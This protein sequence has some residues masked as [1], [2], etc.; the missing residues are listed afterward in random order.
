MR[1]GGRQPAPLRTQARAVRLGRLLT[2]TMAPP[3]PTP[4]S[5]AFIDA[6]V[7]EHR[8]ALLKYLA[9]RGVPAQDAED[10]LQEVLQGA[11]VAYDRFDPERGS[12]RTWL[13]AIATNRL[14]TNRARRRR[15]PDWPLEAI[16][17][18][19]DDAPSSE[20][21]LIDQSRR[22]VLDWLIDQIPEERRGVFVEHALF[23]V[24]MT[25]VAQMLSLNVSTAWARY[26]AALRDVEAAARRWRAEQRRHGRDDVPVV[27]LPLLEQLRHRDAA[28]GAGVRVPQHPLACLSG[29]VCSIV[30]GFSSSSA[31]QIRGVVLALL[32]GAFGPVDVHHAIAESRAPAELA[33]ASTASPL[34]APEEAPPRSGPA[35]VEPFPPPPP[36]RV[37][38]TAA[39]RRLRRPNVSTAGD[40]LRAESKLV[41]VAA[42]AMRS[43]QHQEARRL[44][45]RHAR[46]FPNGMLARRRKELL[47][48][49]QAL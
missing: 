40:E 45:E 39:A 11:Y 48:R 9:R 15:R 47:L 27:L 16:E 12:P 21:R 32:L 18:V 23:E 43:G 36:P 30:R 29:H 33:S 41:D 35:A 42:L 22:R 4:P 44:L 31:R 24:P 34:V 1:G 25:E 3:R 46:E 2:L 5:H 17:A 38:P 28:P 13:F 19:S 26:R 49:L 37:A 20:V 7:A 8:P 6:V 14:L 10:I